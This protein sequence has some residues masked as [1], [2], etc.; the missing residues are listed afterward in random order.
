MT[1]IVQKNVYTDI[2]L[3]FK[4][5]PINGDINVLYDENAVKRSLKNLIMLDG[6]SKFHPE[7]EVGIK[8]YLFDLITPITMENLKKRIE[9]VLKQHAPRIKV[10]NIDVFTNEIQDSYIIEIT[11]KTINIITPITTTLY[12]QRIR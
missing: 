12:L 4:T 7:N 1:E 8:Q 9:F 5:H 2:D 6:W 3:T 11:F 10:I